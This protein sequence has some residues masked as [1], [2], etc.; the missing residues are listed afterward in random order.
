MK[1]PLK[2]VLFIFEEYERVTAENIYLLMENETLTLKVGELEGE[3]ESEKTL[4]VNPTTTRKKKKPGRKSGFKGTSMRIP[5]HVDEV[6]E[7]ILPVCPEC[8]TLLGAPSE[9]VTHYVEDIKPSV[10][11]VTQVNTHRYYCS[12]CRK[13][14]SAHSDDAMPKCRLG[15]KVTLLG[16]IHEI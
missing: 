15:L 1:E 6:C 5:D 9:T 4:K 16:S 11:H 10:P 8:G 7:V 14:V 3:K 2:R 13:M 12:T